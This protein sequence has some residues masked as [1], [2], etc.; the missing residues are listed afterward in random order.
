MI[1]HSGSDKFEHGK[2]RMWQN[3]PRWFDMKKNLALDEYSENVFPGALLIGLN[4]GP[5]SD[6]YESMV[7]HPLSRPF[8]YRRCFR[9]VPTD[10]PM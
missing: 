2:A 5:A 8:A 1:L 6:L 9:T 10:P 4:C 3:P 7:P